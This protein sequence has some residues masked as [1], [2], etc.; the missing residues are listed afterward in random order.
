M[1][2]RLR[3]GQVL[4]MPEVSVGSMEGSTISSCWLD[5][6]AG[7]VPT[8]FRSRWPKVDAPVACG[9][10]VLIPVC[11]VAGNVSILTEAESCLYCWLSAQE[12]DSV[13]S[14]G[15]ETPLVL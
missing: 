13:C 2:A 14:G 4:R 10:G 1:D 15:A 12:A 8:G 6:R 7:F 11:P 3:S 5:T 9:L